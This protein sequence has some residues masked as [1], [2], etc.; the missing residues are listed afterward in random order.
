MLLLYIQNMK[1]KKYNQIN[2][3]SLTFLTKKSISLFMDIQQYDIISFIPNLILYNQ[4]LIRLSI[5]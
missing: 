1:L 2:I 3:T 4:Q 5:L